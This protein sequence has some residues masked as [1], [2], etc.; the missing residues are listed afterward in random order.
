MAISNLSV[1]SAKILYALRAFRHDRRQIGIFHF[2]YDAGGIAPAK[3]G[4]S[5]GR[6]AS[7]D[8]LRGT[9]ALVVVCYHFIAAFLPSLSPGQTD[10]PY[11]LADTPLG[12]LINGPF[13][14][15]IFFVLSG[16]VIAQAAER[17]N[18]A[19]YVT[20]GLRY[21]RLALPATASV[22]FAWCLLTAIPTATIE[23][24]RILPHPWLASTYQE[25][26]PSLPDAIWEGLVGIFLTGGSLFN[27]ALWTMRI[28]LIGSVAI[29]GLFAIKNKQLRIAGFLLLGVIAVLKPHYLGFVIGAALRSCRVGGRISPGVS[30]AALL[31]GVLLGAPG[32][33]FAE[34]LG[35]PTMPY[36]WTLGVEN[37]FVAPIAA[38]LILYAVL[39]APWLSR[40]MA[41]PIPCYL[42]K[43]SFPLYLVH[44]PLLYT[45]MAAIYPLS[46]PASGL[47]LAGL[48][49]AFLALSLTLA[50]AGTAW[51]DAPILALLSRMRR[52]LQRPTARPAHGATSLRGASTR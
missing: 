17:R 28:E 41:M 1:I 36:V 13:A 24:G 20:I 38:G 49:T 23:L 27:N 19:L 33:G 35:L 7:L 29:Y 8:G 9:A 47:V 2:R 31:A 16:F 12:I 43:I 39:T 26:I 34:R 15:S 14:V 22:I 42:G 37:G 3:P 25:P 50:A 6:N 44:V 32:P 51:V 40:V 30:S 18:D 21:M 46:A 4:S 10:H 5:A 11:W 45:V 48:F 52:Q